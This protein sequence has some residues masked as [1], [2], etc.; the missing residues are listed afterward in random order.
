MREAIKDRGRLQHMVQAIDKVFRFTADAD[1]EQLRGDSVVYYAVVYNIQ[2]VGEAAYKL[3]NEFRA[4]HPEV[5]WADIIG[6]RHVLVHGY[7]TVD[8]SLVW[9]VVKRQLVPLREQLLAYIAEFPE[10]GE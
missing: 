2:V 7:Y 5:E 1:Y 3:T 4:A 6:M 8:A 10:D 9:N